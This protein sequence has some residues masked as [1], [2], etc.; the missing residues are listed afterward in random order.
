MPPLM[1]LV[2]SNNKINTCKE[3]KTQELLLFGLYTVIRRYGSESIRASIEQYVV[4]CAILDSWTATLRFLGSN[5]ATPL[6]LL[7][8]LPHA[9]LLP[10]SA[11]VY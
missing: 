10:S 5:I 11:E 2:V 1:I 4:S 3:W 9:L 7:S 8:F 6:P